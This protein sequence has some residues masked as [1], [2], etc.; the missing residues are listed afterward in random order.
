MKVPL[1][2]AAAVTQMAVAEPYPQT[3]PKTYQ[4]F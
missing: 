3:K 2:I 1:V 4:L